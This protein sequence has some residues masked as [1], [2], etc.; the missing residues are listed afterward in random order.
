MARSAL[1]ALDAIESAAFKK[2]FRPTRAATNLVTR[3]VTV[4][5]HHRSTRAHVVTFCVSAPEK[6]HRKDP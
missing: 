2:A 4:G 1:D 6:A 5:G 3:V